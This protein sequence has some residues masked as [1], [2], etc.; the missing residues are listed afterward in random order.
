MSHWALVHAVRCVWKIVDGVGRLATVG[1]AVPTYY[2]EF[3]VARAGK[4]G[5]VIDD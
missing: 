4:I 1:G 5:F 3:A 2:T